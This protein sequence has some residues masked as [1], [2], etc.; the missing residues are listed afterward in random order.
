LVNPFGFFGKIILLL[1]MVS[2]KVDGNF[3][4]KNEKNPIFIEDFRVSNFSIISSAKFF[5]LIF[6]F[7][8][9][10]QF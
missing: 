9:S 7:Q 3:N 1:S 6:V 2:I 5:L 8:L 4:F 10:K